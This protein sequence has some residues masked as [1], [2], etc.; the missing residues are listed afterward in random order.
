MTGQVA[1]GPPLFNA[2]T[3]VSRI[4]DRDIEG[5]DVRALDLVRGDVERTANAEREACRPGKRTLVLSLE[6]EVRDR[7]RLGT[8]DASERS[9]LVGHADVDDG[10]ALRCADEFGGMRGA[11][12]G[13]D[14]ASRA[15]CIGIRLEH[16]R[17]SG[18]RR[19]IAKVHI[20]QL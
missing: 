12:D 19:Q 3:L 9:R 5:A 10:G 7:H 16:C 1:T 4:L 8:A 20:F 11:S 2:V 15:E 13:Y 14:T 6:R 18:G 17:S